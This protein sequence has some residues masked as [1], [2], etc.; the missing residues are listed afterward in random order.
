MDTSKNILEEEF[1]F[2]QQMISDTFKTESQYF[3]PPYEGIADI[4][5]G[6]RRMMWTR[7][8][9]PDILSMFQ[10]VDNK[11]AYHMIVVKSSL[12]FY[13]ILIFASLDKI[14]DIINIGPFRDEEITEAFLHE[15]FRDANVPR[16]KL[17]I[18]QNFYHV[19]PNISVDDLIIF[20][21]HLLAHFIPEFADI[22]PE[23]LNYSEEKH[24]IIPSANEMDNF[25][26]QY[27]MDYRGYLKHFLDAVASGDYHIS[28]DCLTQLT[29]HLR[30]KEQTSI[31][32]LR[33]TVN[34][35]NTYCE[36][37]LMQTWVHP[38]YV[39]RLFHS[40]MTLI[41]TTVN[42]QK[43]LNLPSE[44]A[45]KYCLLVR[46][47]S[48]PEYSQLIRNVIAYIDQYLTTDLSLSVIADYFQKN[49]SFL[50]KEFSRE[51]G[52]SLTS[53]IRKQRMQLAIKY[54]NTTS[55]SI[56]EVAGNVGIQDYGYFTKQFKKEIGFTPQEYKK[57]LTQ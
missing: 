57:M 50:S 14:P 28:L 48:Y 8:E 25:L 46:N 37:R 56:S 9:T 34:N 24:Q 19:L 51:T 39:M 54:F 18:L 16:E 29:M 17:Q 13:N 10:Q 47:Y 1:P 38:M 53:Y 33:Q 15:V 3:T 4:D 26:F 30:L 41:N 11:P 5:K 35:I 52:Q 45:R 31:G 20:L 55:L 44:I 6:F 2:I 23:T 7:Y 43:L 32:E 49:A 22:T 21:T 36:L 40:Y 42:H 27:A 12:K